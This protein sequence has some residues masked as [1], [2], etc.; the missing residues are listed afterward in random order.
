MDHAINILRRFGLV[1]AAGDATE[2]FDLRLVR[3]QQRESRRAARISPFAMSQPHP[4]A[5]E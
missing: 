4:A 1:P 3:L 5:E 2:I